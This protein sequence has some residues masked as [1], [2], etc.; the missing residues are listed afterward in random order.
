MTDH[1]FQIVPIADPAIV[2]AFLSIDRSR[3]AYMV[4]D[5]SA[6]Y[7]SPALFYGAFD[8]SR[9]TEAALR[10]VVLIYTPITPPPMI[11]AGEPE[12][13]AAI[14]ATLIARGLVTRVMY[15]TLPEHQSALETH[16]ALDSPATSMWRMAITRA[17]FQ[18]SIPVSA[19]IRRLTGADAAAVQAVFDSGYPAE[20]MDGRPHITADLL[21][22]GVFYGSFSA[23]TINQH[24]PLLAAIAGT[25]IVAVAERIATVGY[26]FTRPDQRGRGHATLATAA[27]TLALFETGIDLVVLNVKQDNPPAIRAYERIG[28]VRHNALF[29]G[30]A[31]RR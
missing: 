9:P 18:P 31:E 21:N 4:G 10:A 28:Y 11:S 2:R 20:F 8:T 25:H 5:L 1:L 30:F 19:S 7:W 23:M 15:H 12:A 24:E 3:H 27:V 29:E 17:Q 16:F 14:F 26:V 13:V 22:N 6:P